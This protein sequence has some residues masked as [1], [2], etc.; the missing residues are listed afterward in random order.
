MKLKLRK[1]EKGY[2]PTILMRIVLTICIITYLISASLNLFIGLFNQYAQEIINSQSFPTYMYFYRSK[3]ME[4]IINNEFYFII[5]A[6]IQ[7]VM[8]SSFVIMFRGFTTGYYT[9]FVSQICAILFPILIIGQRA[10]AIG[11]IM[12][13]LLLLVFF[14]VEII[15]YQTK[16]KKEETTTN[17]NP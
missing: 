4:L 9:Y 2:R 14:L 15:I 16:P 12:I 7:I 5:I 3:L 17:T 10:I 8:L 11:N 13:A 6:I 1:L